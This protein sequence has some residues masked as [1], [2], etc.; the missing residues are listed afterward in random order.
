M[1]SNSIDE[2]KIKDAF[3]KIEQEQIFRFWDEL[4]QTEKTFFLQQLE[5]VDPFECQL[6]W[7]EINFSHTKDFN[8]Q[9]SKS[10]KCEKPIGPRI[11][12]DA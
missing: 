9:T 6:A 11:I 12:V 4:N 8:P 5:T 3:A 1:I 10:K 2:K 7:Q